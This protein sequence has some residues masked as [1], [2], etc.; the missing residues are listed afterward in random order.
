MFRVNQ[1]CATAACV[2]PTMTRRERRPNLGN[3]ARRRF[4]ESSLTAGPARRTPDLS[5][6]RA[7]RRGRRMAAFSFRWS[8]V[9]SGA[10]IRS[11][12]G[13]INP[14]FHRQGASCAERREG[15][16]TISARRCAR[17]SPSSSLAQD[18]A[19]SRV[20][21]DWPSVWLWPGHYPQGHNVVLV[22]APGIGK[23]IVAMDHAK[24]LIE[25]SGWPDGQPCDRLPSVMW[26]DT[27]GGQSVVS[28]RL[29]ELGIPEE[30][31]IVP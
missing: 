28:D 30:K 23:S 5:S 11:R 7:E 12:V 15:C 10:L 31:F 17:G 18:T 22:G 29:V 19:L 13:P 4:I 2:P 8:G 3:P 26:I 24:R 16:D 21:M 9:K 25:G 20:K 14:S 6:R 1:G 27:E